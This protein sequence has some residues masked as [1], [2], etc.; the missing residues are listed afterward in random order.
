MKAQAVRELVDKYCYQIGPAS[1]IVVE[2][3]VKRKRL[4]AAR[5]AK[6]DIEARGDLSAARL[7][8]DSSERIG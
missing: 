8:I 5:F 1:V 4:A 6:I 7:Q 2:A 3:Q